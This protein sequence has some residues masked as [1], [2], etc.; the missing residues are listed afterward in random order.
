LS[1][2]ES[3]PRH[4]AYALRT[5][6]VRFTESI[7]AKRGFDPAYLHHSTKLSPAGD[8]FWFHNCF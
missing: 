6:N 4:A 3:L 7:G 8:G 2:Y 5:E 1:K